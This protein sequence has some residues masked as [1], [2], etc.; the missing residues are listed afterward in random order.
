MFSTP[1]DDFADLDA[2]YWVYE[3]LEMVRREEGV[4]SPAALIAKVQ[5]EELKTKCTELCLK[6]RHIQAS[7]NMCARPLLVLTALM[8]S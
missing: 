7:A 1:Q 2:Q 8:L 6:S 4:S 3:R 5:Y